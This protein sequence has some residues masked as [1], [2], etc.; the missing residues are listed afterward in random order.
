MP[1]S[2]LCVLHCECTKIRAQKRAGAVEHPMLTIRNQESV[3]HGALE[4]LS[5]VEGYYRSM[6][7]TCDYSGANDVKEEGMD[8][9]AWSRIPE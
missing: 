7:E 8:V 6:T 1:L 4:R 2:I 5:I 9:S 3:C